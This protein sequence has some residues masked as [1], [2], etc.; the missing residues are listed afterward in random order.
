MKIAIC[1]GLIIGILL[2]VCNLCFATE[3][4]EISV[5]SGLGINST[6]GV[7]IS[8]S[9]SVGYFEIE[10]GYVYHVTNG[11]TSA[12]KVYGFSDDIIELNDVVFD[13]STLGGKQTVDITYSQY[14]YV[15]F[16]FY[17]ASNT[18]VTRDSLVGMTSF[19]DNIAYSLSVGNLSSVWVLVVPILAIS[20]LLGLGFY[21]LKRLLNKIKRAKG[22]A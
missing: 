6:T 16:N 20:V 21:L 14:Q 11:L 7:V 4:V 3:N 10:P 22:G 5:I 1:F 13:V 8:S 19:I 18:T 17:G 15:Y 2:S 12:A 9:S